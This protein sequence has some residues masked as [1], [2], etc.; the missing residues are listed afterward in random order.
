MLSRRVPVVLVLAD[1][2]LFTGHCACP[3][4]CERWQ[5]GCGSC[6]DLAIPPA[7]ER[8]ATARNWQRKRRIVQDSRLFVVAPSRWLLDRA[9]SSLLAP[10]IEDARVVVNGVDLDVFTP[11][12]GARARA[13]LGVDPAATMLLHVATDGAENPFKDFATVRAAVR[14]LGLV[15]A[16]VELVVV[17]RAGPTELL[18][19]GT[20]VHHRPR[21]DS[22]RDLADLYRAAD[23][24]V[25]AAHEES[26]CLTAAEA[27]ACGT[28]VV[29]AAGGGLPEVVDHDRTGLVVGPGDVAGLAAAVRALINDPDRR[30]RMGTTGADDAPRFD[31]RRMVA[32][33]HAC[34]TEAVARRAPVRHAPPVR[35]G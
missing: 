27:L 8:D 29:A 23:V 28:P 16:P 3:L 19:G 30:A 2:W 17:G 20:R 35:Q 24:Y 32:E 33:L 25:H 18:A 1:S 7:V 11:G 10:A 26:F 22:Q 9:R 12:S 14:R 34:C 6:P 31:Q 5:L 4:G 15:G 21:C 13:R